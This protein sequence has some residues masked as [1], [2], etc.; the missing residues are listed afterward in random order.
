MSVSVSVKNFHRLIIQLIDGIPTAISELSFF[1]SVGMLYILRYRSQVIKLE[2]MRRY[3]S[4]RKISSD[5]QAVLNLIK[6]K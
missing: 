1:A 4:E 6:N 5:M 2:V 3:K